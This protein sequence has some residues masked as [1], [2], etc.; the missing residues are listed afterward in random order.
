MRGFRVV[1]DEV[2][3]MDTATKQ[4]FLKGQESINYDMAVVALGSEPEFYSVP[5]AAEFA[6]PL[7]FLTHA[8]RIRDRLHHLIQASHNGLERKF[9]VVVVG[10]GP[11]G[12]ETAAELARFAKSHRCHNGT[13]SEHLTITLLELSP[14]ILASCSPSVVAVAVRRL[15]NLGVRVRTNTSVGE[16]H[17]S[18]VDST[19]YDLLIWAAGVCPAKALPCLHLPLSSHGAV[20]VGPTLAVSGHEDIFALGDAAA[21]LHPTTQKLIPGLAQVALEEAHVVSQNI[22][23]RARGERLIVFR[24]PEEWHTIIP[25]GG[26]YAVTEFWGVVV[27]GFPAYMIRKAVDL[28]YFLGVMSPLQA[29]RIWFFGAKTFAQN[30]ESGVLY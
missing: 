24:P 18:S 12:V 15:K 11:N 22:R 25:L 2:T 4:I 13:L 17:A 30:E 29:L 20:L 8:F 6:L 21:V 27:S 16:V 10:G 26:A 5:G 19:P 23:R 9:D 1:Q 3:G 7:R 28:W 14:R